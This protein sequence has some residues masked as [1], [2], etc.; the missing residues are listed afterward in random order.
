VPLEECWRASP[1]VNGDIPDLSLQTADDLFF[2]FGRV[3]EMHPPHRS[4]RARKRVVDLRYPF[5]PQQIPQ[6]RFTENPFKK[7]AFILQGMPLERMESCN[8]DGFNGNPIHADDS[9]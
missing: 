2:R 4:L 9:S 5:A 8:P 1:Q 7:A 6:F 3:L